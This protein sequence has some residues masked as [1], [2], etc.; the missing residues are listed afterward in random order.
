MV[1][2]S[3][4]TVGNQLEI[5]VLTYTTG[6]VKMVCHFSVLAMLVYGVAVHHSK[7]SLRQISLGAIL[8]TIAGLC[9]ENVL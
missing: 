8:L 6:M 3:K 7:F 9:P 4:D 5:L 1:S 2:C